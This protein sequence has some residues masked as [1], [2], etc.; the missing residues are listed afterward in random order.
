MSLSTQGSDFAAVVLAGDRRPDDPLVRH[1]GACC[2]AL[3]AIDGTPMLQ[4]VVAVLQH[5]GL[6]RQVLLSGPSRR[7]LETAPSL[8]A[9]L[10]DGRIQW[11]EPQASPSTSAYSAMQ[12]LAPGTPVLVTTADHPLLRPEIVDHFLRAALDTHA[13]VVVGLSRFSSIRDRFPDVRKTVLRFRD[14]GFCG[15]NLFAFLTPRSRRVADAWRRV[16]QQRKSPLRVMGQ[17]GWRSVLSY[18]LGRLSLDRAL[19]ELSRRMQVRIRPVIL[20]FPEAAIDVDSIAD[21]R[22]VESLEGTRR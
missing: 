22:L 2:K 5:S 9:A 1:T 18:V 6:V 17:L 4:S 12:R 19:D 13:D 8:K 15:C 7:C 3:V 16:E 10:Q 20:P 21:Q 14:G 11:L